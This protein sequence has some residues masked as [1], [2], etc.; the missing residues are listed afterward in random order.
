MLRNINRKNVDERTIITQRLN[1]PPNKPKTQ[2]TNSVSHSVN[3]TELKQIN[4]K[5]LTLT[6]SIMLF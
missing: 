3:P 5:K 1:K 4:V 6:R 2:A